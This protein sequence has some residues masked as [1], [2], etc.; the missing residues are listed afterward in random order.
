M[1]DSKRKATVFITE[2]TNDVLQ[3]E[4]NLMNILVLTQHAPFLTHPF[5]DDLI[6]LRPE[7]L[8]L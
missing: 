6:N 5:V 2:F 8:E 7:I 4:D 3:L 1:R